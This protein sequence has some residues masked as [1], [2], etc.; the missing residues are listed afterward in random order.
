MPGPLS[1]WVMKRTSLHRFADLARTP[2]RKQA[3]A[4]HVAGSVILQIVFFLHA[5][6]LVPIAASAVGPKTFGYWLASG[7][8]LMGCV[9]L[10]TFGS[11]TATL[12]RCAQAYGA[13]DFQAVRDWYAHGV[14]AALVSSVV[15]GCVTP[16]LA[17]FGPRVLGAPETVRGDLTQAIGLV[18]IGAAL[19][20]LNDT[21]RGFVCSLQRNGVGL[22]AEILSGFAAFA[23]T[24]AGLKH[25]WGVRALGAGVMLRL[26]FACLINMTAAA[27]FMHLAAPRTIWRRSIFNDYL[28]ACLSLWSASA[29]G[30]MVPQLPPLVLTTLVGPESAVAYTATSRPLMICDML[31]GFAIGSMSSAISHMAGDVTARPRL[32]SLLAKLGG[33]LAFATITGAAAYCLGNAAFVKLWMG[34]QYY[35]GPWFT[36]C[37]ATAALVTAQVRWASGIS[38]ALGAVGS[39]ARILSCELLARAALIPILVAGIGPSGIPIATAACGVMIFPFF[40]HIP[41][42]RND[43]L[44]SP[45]TELVLRRL[46]VAMVPLAVATVLSTYWPPVGWFGW[47]AI[48]LPG[49]ICIVIGTMMLFPSSLRAVSLLSRAFRKNRDALVC[50]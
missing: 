27:W 32:H 44:A 7:G 1:S 46:L 42:D 29:V 24:W 18:A 12:Q 6:V 40:G 26:L 20:P 17:I 5:F 50:R 37:A 48:M 45:A 49:T 15:I 2:S 10:T 9:G 33:L 36:V 14:V 19:T 8:L 23:I 39:T 13:R 22:G 3:V 34:E 41:G 28:H 16:P 30:Q 11:A 31:P 21:A 43:R 47:A 35:L 25:G 38:T 4:R